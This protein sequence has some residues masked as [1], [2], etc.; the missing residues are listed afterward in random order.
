MKTRSGAPTLAFSTKTALL[1]AQ[2]KECRQSYADA[3]RFPGR[4]RATV[5]QRREWASG[6][7][8]VGVT[9]QNPASRRPL[10]GE[11]K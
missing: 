5:T 8:D 4:K 10:P 11:P 6:K 7:N 1:H 9:R 3:F 2:L